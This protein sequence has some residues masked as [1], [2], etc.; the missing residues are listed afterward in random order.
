[1]LGTGPARLLPHA[2]CHRQRACTNG[3]STVKGGDESEEESVGCGL[4]AWYST[5]LVAGR[6]L[7]SR[8]GRTEQWSGL[9]QR[10]LALLLA[11]LGAWATVR[12]SGSGDGLLPVAA[13]GG[14]ALQGAAAVHQAAG[15]GAPGHGGGARALPARAAGHGRLAAALRQ[16]R[17]G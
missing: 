8:C 5:A 10:L 1:L 9:E 2:R 15:A 3:S 4:S 13:G 11:G 12:R 6:A 14:V 17:G 7:T 16:R